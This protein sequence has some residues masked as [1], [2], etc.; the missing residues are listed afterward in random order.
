MR[1]LDHPSNQ[2][3]LP[4]L[5]GDGEKLM[6]EARY[7]VATHYDEWQFWCATAR[8]DGDDTGYISS[9]AVTHMMR[10]R[11]R[12]EVKN[13]YTPAFARI[14]LEQMK[15]AERAIY[16]PCFRMGRSKVDSYTEV[17]L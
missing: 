14:F 16:R 2:I 13:A 9:D 5:D 10:H 6:K 8:R 3:A 11:F 15:P 17:T 12:V 7:W 4:G 1:S